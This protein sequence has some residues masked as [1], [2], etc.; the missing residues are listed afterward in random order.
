MT[1][2]LWKM[3]VHIH[4]APL[5]DQK[6]TRY[7]RHSSFFI[8][9]PFNLWV[10]KCMSLLSLKLYDKVNSISDAYLPANK[11]NFP[12]F[13]L[14]FSLLLWPK[15]ISSNLHNPD[16]AVRKYMPKCIVY[17][18]KET[19]D[20]IC[21]PFTLFQS[22]IKT[23]YN[24]CYFLYSE[25]SGSCGEEHSRATKDAGQSWVFKRLM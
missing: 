4:F 11:Q 15:I 25:N 24:Q 21:W 8:Y 19:T 6:M 23:D 1:H 13:C 17:E 16:Y 18:L 12:S 2:R 20:I 3:H 10:F 5:L 9:S 14:S 7:A 22:K